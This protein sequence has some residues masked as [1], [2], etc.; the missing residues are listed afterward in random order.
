MIN[1]LKKVQEAYSIL[2][3]GDAGYLGALSADHF[4]A[5]EEGRTTTDNGANIWVPWY[6]AHKTSEMLLDVYL[7]ATDAALQET[8]WE[9]LMYYSD[10]VSNMMSGRSDVDRLKILRM[11]YGGMAEVFYQ[12][13]AIKRE[14]KHLKIAKF[15]EEEG[16]LDN[17][18]QNKDILSGLHANTA[19]PKFLSTAAAYEATGD[20]YYKTVCVNAF[21]MIMTRTYANGGT[22]R[23]E[24]WQAAGRL[25]T[26]N[27]TCET[28]CSYNMIK[29]AD[30][31]YR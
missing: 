3:P 30:Y 24:H 21:E 27:D 25:Q 29:L 8:A 5:I 19:I 13:Y 2:S 12:I 26:N 6:H 9:M 1:E 17:I 16:L 11:E 7:Y 23:G 4:H 28:C 10:W 15:F 31:L 14:M 18:Y 22:S 20:E